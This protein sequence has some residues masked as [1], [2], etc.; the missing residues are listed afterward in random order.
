MAYASAQ[1]AID[2]Y[3]TD[4]VTVA[5]DRDR[6]GVLDT[7]AFERALISASA[8][9][10]G[11]FAGRVPGWPWAS[12]PANLVKLTVDLAVYICAGT[13]R[14]TLTD[15]MKELNTEALTYLKAVGTGKLRLTQDG[16]LQGAELN[17]TATA[18][19]SKDNQ[20]LLTCG[21]RKFVRGQ[22]GSI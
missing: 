4:Y 22:M 11:Y 19:S 17:L 20:V 9:V 15:H 13:G 14:D 2:L 7:D 6:S 12:P 18:T 10:D 16:E 5:C 21:S 1:D 8:M 3:G